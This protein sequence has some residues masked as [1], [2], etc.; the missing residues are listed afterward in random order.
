MHPEVDGKSKELLDKPV[1]ERDLR[2]SNSSDS[3]SHS[4]ECLSKESAEFVMMSPDLTYLCTYFQIL[5]SL[6]D[7][8]NSVNIGKIIRRFSFDT[9]VS[10]IR[11]SGECWPLKR[12]LRALLNRLYYFRPEI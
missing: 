4:R 7:D 11:E 2:E 9:L 12:N 6:I 10:F 5:S 3:H 1:M 8:N